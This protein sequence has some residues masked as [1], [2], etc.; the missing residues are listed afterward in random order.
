MP[1]EEMQQAI[2]AG[3]CYTIPAVNRDLNYANYFRE[4]KS[5][6]SMLADTPNTAL[7]V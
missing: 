2:D 4:G 7:A 1:C 5:E 3:S 6:I